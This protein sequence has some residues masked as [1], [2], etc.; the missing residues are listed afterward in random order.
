M[1]IFTNSKM[2][3]KI[4]LI[5]EQTYLWNASQWS[6]SNGQMRCVQV[7]MKLSEWLITTI[8]KQSLLEASDS[9]K[10]AGCRFDTLLQI[11]PHMFSLCIQSKNSKKTHKGIAF[12]MAHIST[13]KVL[14]IWVKR[15]KCRSSEIFGVCKYKIF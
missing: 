11:N 3:I 1:N 5:A 6:S 8:I 4:Q 12:G 13:E 14:N 2:L 9:N 7:P 15:G 10:V